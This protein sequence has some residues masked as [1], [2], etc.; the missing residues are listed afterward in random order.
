MNKID[1]YLINHISHILNTNDISMIM[2]ILLQY[3]YVAHL[4][5]TFKIHYIFLFFIV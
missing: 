2:Y 1:V 4:N 3:D 5:I